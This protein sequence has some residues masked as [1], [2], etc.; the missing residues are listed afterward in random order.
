M[1][2]PLWDL[3]QLKHSKQPTCWGSRYSKHTCDEWFFGINLKPKHWCNLALFRAR[4]PQPLSPLISVS[5]KMLLIATHLVNMFS[6]SCPWRLA[7][8]SDI[9]AGAGRAGIPI[10]D[11]PKGVQPPGRNQNIVLQVLPF[12]CGSHRGDCLLVVMIII[13][14][15]IKIKKRKGSRRQNLCL[16]S[17]GNISDEA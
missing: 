2:R 7:P 16:H 8:L 13:M 15:R 3:L 14:R 1:L 17:L 11:E 6:R 10:R 4:L 12:C 9:S 5:Y